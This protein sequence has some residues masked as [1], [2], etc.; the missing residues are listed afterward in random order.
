MSFDDTFDLF[1]L[2]LS[3]IN[4]NKHRSESPVIDFE[5]YD[6]FFQKLTDGMEKFKDIE[7][8][9]YPVYSMI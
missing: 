9:E 6:T 5:H 4:R 7:E 1:F 2:N 3:L 8:P